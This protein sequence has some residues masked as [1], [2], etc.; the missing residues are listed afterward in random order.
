MEYKN[1]DSEA[2]ILF[3]SFLY[4]LYKIKLIFVMLI[5]KIIAFLVI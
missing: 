4:N 1:S 5:L 3:V 2:I